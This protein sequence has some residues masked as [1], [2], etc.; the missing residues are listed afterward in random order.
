MSRLTLAAPVQP[1]S[2]E[3]L[4][5]ASLHQRRKPWTWVAACICILL[6]VLV[7]RSMATNPGFGWGIVAEY[8][9]APQVLAGL[10]TTL[11]LTAV[12]MTAALI[13]GVLLALSVGSGNIVLSN[14]A[15]LYIWFF[16]AVPLLV[17]VIFCYNLAALYPSLGLSLPFVGTVY[18]VD[19]NTIITSLGAAIIAL[20]LNEAAFMAEIVRSGLNSV[21]VGQRE[22]ARTLGMSS[23]AAFIRIIL[24]QAMRVIIPPTGNEAISMLKYTSLVSVIALPELLYSTQLISSQNFEVIPMLLVATIWYF[25]VTTILM[26]I[27][28][29]IERKFSKSVSR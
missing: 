14:L 3:D 18:Q 5:R 13:L 9:F 26:M 2:D 25:V 10:V 29:R 1:F 8:L 24:P 11:M 27:Q 6:A 12:S 16:R 15:K 21:D 7:I 17:Q 23:R 4:S 22:A 20:S 28:S 19:T